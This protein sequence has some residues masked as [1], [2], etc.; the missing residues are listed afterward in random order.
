MSRAQETK[1][2]A[3]RKKKK[4]EFR[5]VPPF[6]LIRHSSTSSLFHFVVFYMNEYHQRNKNEFHRT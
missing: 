1:R 6:L 4:R 5:Y 3:T 2:R